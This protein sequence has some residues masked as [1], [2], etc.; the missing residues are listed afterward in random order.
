VAGVRKRSFFE[1]QV[2]IRKRSAEVW[3]IRPWSVSP[4]PHSNLIIEDNKFDVRRY[5]L[6]LAYTGKVKGIDIDP[7]IENKRFVLA[8]IA[9]A[10]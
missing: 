2:V 4:A 5:L 3:Y 9:R 6:Q 7:L 10:I 1:V 8:L